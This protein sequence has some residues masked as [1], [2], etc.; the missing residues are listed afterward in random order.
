[1][2]TGGP[3][4]NFAWQYADHKEKRGATAPLSVSQIRLTIY[5]PVSACGLIHAKGERTRPR[6]CNYLLG[7]CVR[8]EAAAVFAALLDLGLLN[9][10]PAADAA[11]A[12]VTSLFGFFAI[13]ELPLSTCPNS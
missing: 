5:R 9:T 10:F 8:A 4:L 11:F 3:D 6:T 1:M 13:L 7:L 12:L 2:V